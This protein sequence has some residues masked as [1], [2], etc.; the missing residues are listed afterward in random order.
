MITTSQGRPEEARGLFKLALEHSLEHGLTQRAA[1]ACGNLSDI[2][3]QRDRYEE[4]LGYLHQALALARKDGDRPNEWFS[5]S[6]MT[7]ALYMTGRW[8]EAIAALAEIPEERLPIGGTLISPLTSVLEIHLHRGNLDEARRI[9]SIYAR[10]AESGDVQ[11][12]ACYA[13]AE[14]ALGRAEGV[15]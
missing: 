9:F 8:D 3:F 11:D 6:E 1:N 5:F 14:A 15:T 7:Y 12:Q 4:A 10:L 2:S 13:C